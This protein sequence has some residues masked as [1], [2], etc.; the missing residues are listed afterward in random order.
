[1]ICYFP[2]KMPAICVILLHNV[3]C[4]KFKPVVMS[5]DMRYLVSSVHISQLEIAPYFFDAVC[6]SGE[7]PAC[8][9]GFYRWG[10]PILFKA[11][12]VHT[13]LGLPSPHCWGKRWGLNL[14]VSFKNK[15]I[16][17]GFI[18]ILGFIFP[19]VGSQ[20]FHRYSQ[21]RTLNWLKKKVLAPYEF[22]TLSDNVKML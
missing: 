5:F 20:K 17:I 10:I 8:G 22:R 15:N 14:E 13:F 16:L 4:I 7:V 9:P 2:C 6:C 21:D 11:A 1:M 18:W 3:I 19:E 12:K